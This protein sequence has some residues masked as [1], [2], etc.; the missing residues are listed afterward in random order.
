MNSAR[1]AL[2]TTISGLSS[3]PTTVEIARAIKTLSNLD[4]ADSGIKTIRL[5][6][7]S[8]FTF[9][10][11]VK[12]L[13]VRGY[14]DGFRLET[15]VSPFGQYVQE[16]MS[17]ASGIAAFK[18]DAVVLAVRLQDAC[19]LIYENF[20]ALDEAAV[21]SICNE[22]INT[23]R[24]AVKSFRKQSQ[25]S[26]LC[27]NYELPAY[28]A[29]G[30]ADCNTVP[31]QIRTI[32]SLNRTLNEI[33]AETGNMHIIDVDRFTACVGRSRIVDPKLWFWGR[34]P[35]A[36]EHQWAYVG[37]ITRM[38][39]ATTG[40]ARKVLALDC[41]NTIWG[42]VLGDVGK[43]GIALGH[44]YP[45]NA[46]VA[47]QK[48]ALD[49]YHR[50][51]VL[52]VASKNEH[53]AVKDVFENHPEMVLRPEH[54]SCFAVNWEPKPQNLQRVAN[55]LNLN[56]DSFVFVD[57]HPVECAMMR[58]MLPQVLT[59][60][61]P[62]DPARYEQ[63]LAQLD[64]FDQLAVSDEDRRRGE[65][66]RKEAARAEFRSESDDLESFFVGL[67]MRVSIAC[68]DESTLARASQLTQRTNQFN[69]TTVRRSE[70]EILELMRA[71]NTDVYTIRLN[72]RFGDNGIVGLAIVRKE[73]DNAVLDTFLMSCRVLGRS[74]EHA[75][76]AWIGK[77][78][79]ARKATVIEGRYN[80]TPK[81]KPFS[82]FFESWGMSHSDE[83]A[84]GT[85][86]WTYALK[87][88]AEALKIPPWIEFESPAN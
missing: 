23:F 44:D 42:G 39:R 78:M 25:A 67:N 88:S 28:P 18:P 85:Q 66:Y 2:A 53:T 30:L 24:Q 54:V 9:E 15:Y 87:P 22:W 48:R 61:L 47:L 84:D 34:I 74:V 35:I 56:L 72:D 12:N 26:I 14:A 55:T 86:R 73:R 79:L 16:L 59:V 57:D 41:D 1:Q 45:G 83:T 71:E 21:Q 20:N 3:P 32:A 4:A 33:A 46:F 5:A 10:P 52:V 27:V 38:L 80:E 31:S 37:E 75:F 62:E 40:K 7:A 64:C 63:T 17:P 77:R 82:R 81:N 69:M 11:L 51:V 65:M 68:N 29:L 43:D 58:E 76:L 60:N 6:I 19:T 36:S 70:S 8:S 49:L 13:T 50:G